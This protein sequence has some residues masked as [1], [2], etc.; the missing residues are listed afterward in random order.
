MMGIFTIVQAVIPIAFKSTHNFI[1][2]KWGSVSVTS[3]IVLLTY[4]HILHKA[5]KPQP[6]ARANHPTGFVAH[7]IIA[8]VQPI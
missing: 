1:Q 6:H 5:T 7:A 3:P 4:Q 2:E 8:K